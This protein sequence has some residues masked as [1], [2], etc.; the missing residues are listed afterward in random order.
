MADITQN[1]ATGDNERPVSLQIACMN[2][3]HKL[4]YCDERHSTPGMVD[5]SS[6]TR[7]FFCIKSHDSLGPDAKPVAPKLC[8]P[9]RGCYCK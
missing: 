8:T 5:D 7:V 1:G 9:E 6:D 3:R 2:L 4:M